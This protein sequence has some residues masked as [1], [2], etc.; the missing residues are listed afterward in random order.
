M[1]L[2]ASGADGNGQ[3]LTDA[4]AACAPSGSRIAARRAALE[5]MILDAERALR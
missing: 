1:A 2:F 3:D 5:L 4:I